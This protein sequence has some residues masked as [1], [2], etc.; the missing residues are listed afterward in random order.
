MKD[1]TN[2]GFSRTCGPLHGDYSPHWIMLPSAHPVP[3]LPFHTVS[4]VWQMS[5][6]LRQA[7]PQWCYGERKHRDQAG[8]CLITAGIKGG[9]TDPP[10][11]RPVLVYTGGNDRLKQRCCCSGALYSR[12]IRFAF[13]RSV[14]YAS[15]PSPS[16]ELRSGFGL[17]PS[18]V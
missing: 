13:L 8:V 4:S 17:S 9:L 12:S 7:Q 18:F 14:S 6:M 3:C 2:T 15:P 11:V 16:S 5:G 10:D 1:L